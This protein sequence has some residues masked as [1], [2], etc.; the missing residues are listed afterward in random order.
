VHAIDVAII[1]AGPYG[2]SIAAHLQARG[3]DFR[4]FGTPMEAWISYMPAG[5]MLKSDGSSS[6]LS[7]PEGHLTLKKFCGQRGLEHHDTEKPVPRDTFIEYGLAFQRRFVPMVE[8]RLLVSLTRFS[9][10]FSLRF[11]DGEVVEARRVIVAVGITPFR[12]MPGFLG[13]LPPEYLSHSSQFGTVD[14]FRGKAVAV[15]GAGASALDLAALL[16]EQGAETSVIARRPELDFHSFPTPRAAWRRV[17]RPNTGIGLGWRLRIFSDAPQV[18]RALP[19]KVRR[20]QVGTLLGP[21]GGWFMKDRILGRVQLLTGRTTQKA[22]IRNGRIH[23]GLSTSDGRQSEVAADHVIA[24]TGYRIDLRQLKFL[25]RETLARIRSVE[26]EPLL[27]SNFE[28]TVPG[29]FFVGPM[30]MSSFGPVARFVYGAKYTAFRIAGH[31]GRSVSRRYQ[32]RVSQPGRVLAPEI[33]VDHD[34]APP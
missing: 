15:L 8:S 32:V 7:E 12:W 24:A 20:H 16:H 1:G 27:S 30:S 34:L 6:D 3:I 19:Q 2:L 10:N 23:L 4:I 21:S 11:A 13:G 17:L 26:H 29:L 14:H 33:A 31:L 28:S 22:F 5:M 9:N 25:T 18:F